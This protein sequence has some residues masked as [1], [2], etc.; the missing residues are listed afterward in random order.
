MSKFSVARAVL[1]LLALVSPAAAVQVLDQVHNPPTIG[2]AAGVS[3]DVMQG[4]VFQIGIT[5]TLTQLDVLG[6]AINVGT[7]LQLDIRKV[8][9]LSTSVGH[10]P[11]SN[12][13][14][15]L[16]AT[17][18]TTLPSVSPGAGNFT[19]IPLSVPVTAGEQL[20]F[21][22]HLDGNPGSATLYG[23]PIISDGYVPGNQW[24]Y[25]NP[26]IN[27]GSWYPNGNTGLLTDLAFQTWVTEVPEPAA[28]GSLGLLTAALLRRRA[29]QKGRA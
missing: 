23:G 3:G 9:P 25:G 18:V 14:D 26:L 28:L 7:N 24:T 11:S 22:F 15:V 21:V 8:N 2:V 6:L 10:P 20:A 5:G 16:F 19:S 29:R 1:S 17:T 27:S 13:L 12:P 4:Q